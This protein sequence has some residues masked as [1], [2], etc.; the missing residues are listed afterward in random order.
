MLVLTRRVGEAVIAGEVT[1]RFLGMKG[2]MVKLGFEAD[3]AVEI[4]REELVRDGAPSLP[5]ER[6][7]RQA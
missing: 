1:V 7:K 5:P 2:G 4:W 3:A 6:L